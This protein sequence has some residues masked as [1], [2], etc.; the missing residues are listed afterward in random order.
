MTR[1]TVTPLFEKQDWWASY[2]DEEYHGYDF[3]AVQHWYREN[4]NRDWPSSLALDN[5][6]ETEC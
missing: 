3:D 6:D 1:D 4:L 2:L 5:L